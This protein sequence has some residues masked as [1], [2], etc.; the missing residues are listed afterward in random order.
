[1]H[2]DQLNISNTKDLFLNRRH[3]LKLLDS[4]IVLIYFAFIV[5]PILYIRDQFKH[6][7]ELSELS[8]FVEYHS[9]DLEQLKQEMLVF[10]GVCMIWAEHLEY[11]PDPNSR[12]TYQW[13]DD[14]GQWMPLSEESH[15]DVF[16][17][18]ESSAAI[19]A[20]NLLV[21]LNANRVSVSL[22]DDAREI[23]VSVAAKGWVGFGEY[24]DIVSRDDC[25]EIAGSQIAGPSDLEPYD[26]GNARIDDC[27]FAR[28]A[29]Y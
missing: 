11:C 14:L 4:L 28:W 15:E 23:D 16:S 24:A 29:R 19:S 5:L 3:Y 7:G 6:S 9:N 21:Q 26:Q 20:R 1:M 13:N 25:G 18:E 17:V 12:F 22:V 2:V 10:D 27:W 8:R